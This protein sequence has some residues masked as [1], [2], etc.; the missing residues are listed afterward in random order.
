MPWTSRSEVQATEAFV[1]Q[2]LNGAIRVFGATM[3]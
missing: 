1:C 2:A 3:K